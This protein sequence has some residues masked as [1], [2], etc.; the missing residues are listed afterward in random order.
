MD[1]DQDG[2]ADSAWRTMVKGLLAG[3]LTGGTGRVN[4]RRGLNQVELMARDEGERWIL[5][6]VVL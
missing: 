3:G 2:G 5:M 6:V 1:E 4:G